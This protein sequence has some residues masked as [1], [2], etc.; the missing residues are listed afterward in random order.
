MSTTQQDNVIVQYVPPVSY[1]IKT[2]G[3]ADINGGD[4]V[5][6]DTSAKVVKSLD[7]DAH[8]ASF[9]GLAMNGSYIQ[10]YTTKQYGAG[11]I[12]VLQKGRC[13]ALTT[14]GDTYHEGD[15]LYTG[16][17]AQTVTNTVGGNSNIIGYVKLRPGITSLA[18]AAGVFVEFD[19]AVKFPTTAFA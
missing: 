9:A 11:S 18:Y 10:P 8:A 3:T 4:L 15:A 1:P 12:P 19:L 7:S 2:D 16:A 6:F 13:K 5:Y 17:D 14:S